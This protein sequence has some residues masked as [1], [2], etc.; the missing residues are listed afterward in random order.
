MIYVIPYTSIIEQTATVFREALGTSEDVLEH[1]ASFDWE[2]AR[3]GTEQA[4]RRGADGSGETAQGVPR[5]GT[6]RSW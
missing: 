4:R 2:P 5:T 3:Q 1:H 6:R